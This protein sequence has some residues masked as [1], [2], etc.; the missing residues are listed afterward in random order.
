MMAFLSGKKTYLTALAGAIYGV[1]VATKVVPSELSVW[2]VIVSGNVAAWRSAF[3]KA[4]SEPPAAITTA[5]PTVDTAAIQA[6][7]AAISAA[8]EP[9][10]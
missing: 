8:V 3:A 1:L 2:S 10:S 9:K 4:V 6:A 5:I 7:V